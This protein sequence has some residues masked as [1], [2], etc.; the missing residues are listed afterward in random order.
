M[1]SA[2]RLGSKAGDEEDNEGDFM[3]TPG[4]ERKRGMDFNTTPAASTRAKR[5]RASAG[6]TKGA[7]L[8]LRDQEK[9]RD[10]TPH[11]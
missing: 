8:T 4:G 6:A 9:V 3:E 10:F 11:P 1:G 7:P 5:T 2:S